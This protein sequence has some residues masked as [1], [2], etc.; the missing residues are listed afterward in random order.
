[1][2]S[3]RPTNQSQQETI[4]LMLDELAQSE[5]YRAYFRGFS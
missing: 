2:F 3:S 4:E 5:T 1:M